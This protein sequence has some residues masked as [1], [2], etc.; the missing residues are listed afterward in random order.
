[1]ICVAE[2]GIV[3][4]PK[5]RRARTARSH[6]V[7][8][9]DPRWP[10]VV[11]VLT[12]LRAQKR[13]SVRIVDAECR[14]GALL[15][16][17]VRCARA[18]GFTAIEARGVD[19]AAPRISRAR[20]AA[21]DLHDPAIGITFEQGAPGVIGD[22]AAFPADIVLWHGRTAGNDAAARRSVASA[23]RALIADAP[24]GAQGAA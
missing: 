15:L 11:A 1:M 2:H 3:G 6:T 23:A 8:S 21:A 13:R 9:R 18:L 19:G 10:Q 20:A 14:S 17:A 24:R 4:V 7:R 5:A 16:C 12:A 22:E